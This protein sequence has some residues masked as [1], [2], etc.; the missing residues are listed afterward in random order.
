MRSDALGNPIYEAY[1]GAEVSMI[2]LIFFSVLLGCSKDFQEI[3]MIS[4]SSSIY[5]M[6]Y[7]LLKK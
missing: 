4:T 2:K 5:S 6:L 3:E 1:C 7:I